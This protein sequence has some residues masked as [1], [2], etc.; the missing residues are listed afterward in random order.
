M[1]STLASGEPC[2]ARA[3]P[4]VHI[5][6]AHH[7]D[8]PDDSIPPRRGFSLGFGVA[9]LLAAGVAYF[10]FDF[11]LFRGP[12]WRGALV[13]FVIGIG[14]AGLALLLDRSV[15]AKSAAI[16]RSKPRGPWACPECGAAYV[17]EATMCSDC[18][19]PLVK[20]GG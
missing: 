6:V 13:A 17:P 14:A 3:D 19:V 4:R 5:R 9:G 16:R 2:V 12:A 20:S 8:M 1:L 11:G 7:I 15:G 18:H 10:A